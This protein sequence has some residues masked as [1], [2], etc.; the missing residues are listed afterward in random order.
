MRASD[1]TSPLTRTELEIRRR[2]DAR[3]LPLPTTRSTDGFSARLDDE[4][5]PDGTYELRARAADSAGNEQSTNREISG[6]VAARR[7]PERV[8]TRLVAGQVKRVTARRSRDGRRRTR[9]VIVVRPTVPYGRTIPIRG[10]LTTPGGNAVA[11]GTIEVWERSPAAARRM[12]AHRGNRYGYSRPLQVQGVAGT[13]PR[14]AV[15]LSRHGDRPGAHHGGGDQG[16]RDLHAWIESQKRRKRGRDRAPRPDPW[17][18]AASSGQ[19]RSASGV[20]ARE[21]VDVR[22]ATR[23]RRKRSLELPISLHR[24]A[25]HGSVPLPRASSSGIWVPLRHRCL[26]VCPRAGQG[27][28]TKSATSGCTDVWWCDEASDPGAAELRERHGDDRGLHRA[29][30]DLVRA[31][32]AA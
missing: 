20:L 18:A 4:H 23:E 6:R 17:P 11:G 30:R 28:V 13:E 26:A 9:R 29:G 25:G 24:D 15:P 12:A 22:N 8:N 27:L 7:V 5:L 21:V 2:G 10:R 14:A 1:S 3:W 19:A 31:D 32:L 16:D